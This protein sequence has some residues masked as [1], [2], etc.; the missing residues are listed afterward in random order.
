MGHPEFDGDIGTVNF[1]DLGEGWMTAF[2]DGTAWQQ[3]LA[4]DRFSVAMNP[5]PE[6]PSTSIAIA[7]ELILG[8][9]VVR[10]AV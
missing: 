5:V 10:A 8:V 9:S 7:S 3:H 2:S 6:E 4:I 1:A